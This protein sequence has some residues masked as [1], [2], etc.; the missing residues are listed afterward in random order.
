MGTVVG[1]NGRSL[2]GRCPKL[3]ACVFVGVA[4]VAGCGPSIEEIRA[5]EQARLEQ[6]ERARQAEETRRKAEE[7]RMARLRAIEEAGNE[8]ARAGRLQEALNVYRD[9]LGEVSRY[10]E[11]D[12][13]VRQSLIR[14][15]RAMPAPPPLPDGVMRSMVRAET[16]VKMGGGGNYAAAGREIEDAVAAAPWLADAYYN[17]GIVQEKG[18]LYEKAMRNFELCLAAAP[19]SPNAGAIQAKIYVSTGIQY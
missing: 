18:E 15:V 9:L 6:E 11:Q 8:A 4:L 5:R 14:V 2:L 12:Q 10:G 19:Q 16:M 7:E 13:R 17:L 1:T 3:A